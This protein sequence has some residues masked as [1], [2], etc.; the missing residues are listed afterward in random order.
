VYH[1]QCDAQHRYDISVSIICLYNAGIVSKQLYT[2]PN[3]PADLCTYAPTAWSTVINFYI[4]FPS[5]SSSCHVYQNINNK[6]PTVIVGLDISAAFDMVNHETLLDCLRNDFGIDGKVFAWLKS[7]LSSRQ[8]FVKI[9]QHTPLAN[10]GYSRY[11]VPFSFLFTH[12][13]SA[14]LCPGLACIFTSLPTICRF[15]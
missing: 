15:T 10:A 13:R 12:H 5:T 9:G 4:L 14:K 2:L 11:L 3:F 8:Q 6:L 1:Y 7:Y